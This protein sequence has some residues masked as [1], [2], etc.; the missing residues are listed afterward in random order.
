MLGQIKNV[1]ELAEIVKEV[2]SKE[3]W[4]EVFETTKQGQSCID[5]FAAL[6]INS[7]DS[8]YLTEIVV[9]LRPE[10]YPIQYLS[11]LCDRLP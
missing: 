5:K 6:L 10:A 1:K 4:L 2:N 3:L 8:L 7:D 9:S 11:L